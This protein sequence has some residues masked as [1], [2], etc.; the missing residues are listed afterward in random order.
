MLVGEVNGSVLAVVTFHPNAAVQGLGW[1][2]GWA[3]GRGL[4]VHPTARGYGLAR[5]LIAETEQLA[6]EAGAPVFAFHTGSF[7]TGAQRL[8]HQ[9]ADPLHVRLV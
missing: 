8:Y 9:L 5:A 6:R 1:P 4:G 7:M 2:P 3:S